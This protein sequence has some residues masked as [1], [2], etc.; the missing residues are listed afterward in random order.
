MPSLVTREVRGTFVAT[1]G[2]RLR[3][4]VVFTPAVTV[5]D[6]AGNVVLMK[7][8][9]EA[10]AN[11][12]GLVSVQLPVTDDSRHTPNDW[13]YLVV[14]QFENGP[15]RDSY[16]IQVP[17]GSTPIELAGQITDQIPPKPSYALVPGPQGPA[18]TV[19]VGTVSTVNPTVNP[20][21]V[22]AGTTGAA[23]LNF[24]LP[25][26]R[27]V[28]VGTTSTL[29]P[30]QNPTVSETVSGAGDKTVNFSLPRSPQFNVGTVSTVSPSSPAT[31]SDSGTSGDI[32]LDFE[33]PQGVKGDTGAGLE[34]P[35]GAD[36]TLLQA[37]SGTTSGTSWTDSPSVAKVSFKTTTPPSLDAEGQVAWDDMDRALSYRADGL[38]IDIGQENVVLI[39]N[40]TGSTLTKGTSVCASGSSAQRLAVV[41]SDASVGGGGCATLGIVMADIPNNQFGF[42][43]TFGLVRGIDTDAF[44][45]GDELFI[46]T[47][48]GV[49][50]ATPAASPGR[51]VT[52][53][54]VVVKGTQGAIFVTIRRGLWLREVDDVEAPTPSNGQTLAYND[55]NSRYELKTLTST[56]ISEGTNL[57]FTNTRADD[58]VRATGVT[59]V[60]HGSDN[61][62]A[63]PTAATVYWKGSVAPD[64]AVNGDLW[65][66]S[67]GD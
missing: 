54:Y 6:L 7:R 8:P 38:T 17:S 29:N 64:N 2:S 43:S 27:N 3:G 60:A 5:Y 26:A 23:I 35:I 67:S 19:N 10:N 56:D 65:Y 18:A 51:R 55:A 39:R 16:W 45:E 30:N 49:L 14:E 9:I 25:R 24:G 66:D 21:V 36:G 53:G 48:P 61:T 11:A 31:V 46:S 15:S 1:D 32:V 50:S 57:Y 41:R 62:F 47:T 34:D 52:V 37:D 28:T 20:T 42:V 22:N 58:R 40:D 12:D 59:T 33:I 63:R 4:R 44:D 13:Y